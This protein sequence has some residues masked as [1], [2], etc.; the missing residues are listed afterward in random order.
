MHHAINTSEVSTQPQ[1]CVH[2]QGYI[3]CILLYSIL[4]L[5]FMICSEQHLVTLNVSES[6]ICG[7]HG[8]VMLTVLF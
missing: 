3:I 1:S 8:N 5:S 7:E 2:E 4:W 6:A